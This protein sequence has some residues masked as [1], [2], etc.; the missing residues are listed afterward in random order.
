MTN[1]ATLEVVCE[2]S[3]LGYI[4]LTLRS[5][6]VDDPQHDRKIGTIRLS[7]E[8]GEETVCVLSGS[9]DARDQAPVPVGLLSARQRRDFAAYLK[10][11]ARWISSQ[12]R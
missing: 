4:A 1:F 12:N 7:G 10:D 2:E 11:M 8:L 6:A 9:F 5:D 3:E